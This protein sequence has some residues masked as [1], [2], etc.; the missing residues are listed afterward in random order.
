[1]KY[2]KFVFFIFVFV[3]LGIQGL[4][5]QSTLKGMSLNGATGLYS[6]PTGRIGWEKDRD[7]GFD[8]GYHFI[9]RNGGVSNIP[10]VS[11]SLYKWVE[12]SAAFDIQPEGYLGSDNPS[13]FIGG[14]KVQLPLTKSAIALGG[15]YQALNMWDTSDKRHDAGQIYVAVSYSG[16]LFNMPAETTIV[17]GK[18]FGGGAATWDIDFG[19]GFDIVILPKIFE[20]YVHW[21]TDFSNF[22]Y[23]VE[24]FGAEAWGR[25]VLNTGIRV[26]LSVIPV[27]K[28]FRFVID[29]LMTDI[30]D[31]NRAFAMSLLFGVPIL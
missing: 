10:K 3:A 18:T 21:V 12:L 8:L 11:M 22:S 4:E 25:G 1:M 16:H 27:F 26:D 15:N 6:I 9:V 20:N 31:V 13:D 17:M 23:S 14:V 5:A 30:F 7:I 28:K 2:C 29:I 24:P 19:M